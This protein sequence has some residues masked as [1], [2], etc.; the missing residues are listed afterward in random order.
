MTSDSLLISKS[1]GGDY[2]L[3]RTPFIKML[4]MIHQYIS[5]YRKQNSVLTA[6]PQPDSVVVPV[7]VRHG[8]WLHS[9]PHQLTTTPAANKSCSFLLCF[10]G[11]SLTY[12]RM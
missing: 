10:Y 6:T 2:D 12:I 1:A 5:V 8:G 11:Q 7:P 9:A 3:K 4:C